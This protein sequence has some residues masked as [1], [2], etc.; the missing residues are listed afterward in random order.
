MTLYLNWC[1]NKK[2]LRLETLIH[3]KIHIET[4]ERLFKLHYEYD[5]NNSTDYNI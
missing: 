3:K 2:E 1:I 4:D 5:I